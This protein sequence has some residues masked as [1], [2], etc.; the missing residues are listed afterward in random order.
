MKKVLLGSAVVL[1]M[2]LGVTSVSVGAG[3]SWKGRAVATT[4]ESADDRVPSATA[5]TEAY[6][7]NAAREGRVSIRWASPTGKGTRMKGTWS[8]WCA[9]HGTGKETF[10]ER[11]FNRW[12]NSGRTIVLR[13]W[14][15]L[16][17]WNECEVTLFFDTRDGPRRAGTATGRIQQR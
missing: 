8:I 14:T 17:R 11:G 15:R 16:A 13:H 12:V 5:F 2:V 6:L 3:S 4:T 1:A 7:T 9:N 10:D